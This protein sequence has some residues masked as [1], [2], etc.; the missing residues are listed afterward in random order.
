VTPAMITEP[1]DKSGNPVGPAF[2]QELEGLEPF[3]TVG[4]HQ[5]S[6]LV[7]HGTADPI[8]PVVIGRSYAERL[9]V[10]LHTIEGAGHTFESLAAQAEA[11]RVTLGFFLDSL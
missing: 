10:Q 1:H 7:V 9:S 5:G 3:D 6:A 11:H 8:V 2:F 4:M